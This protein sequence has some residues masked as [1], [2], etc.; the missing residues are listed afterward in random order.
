MVTRRLVEGGEVREGFT[1]VYCKVTLAARSPF[2]IHVDLRN[3]R[4]SCWCNW[5]GRHGTRRPLGSAVLWRTSVVSGVCRVRRLS[6]A[7]FWRMGFAHT[8]P[9]ENLLD[10]EDFTLEQL[11]EEDDI[12]QECKQLNKKLID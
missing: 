3:F 10:T 6:A 8:S 9:I 2:F 12:I 11:L 5:L 7:M 1:Q 4:S